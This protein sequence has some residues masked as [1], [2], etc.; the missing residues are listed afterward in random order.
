MAYLVLHIFSIFFF[1]LLSNSPGVEE[2][3]HEPPEADQ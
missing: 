1:L 3:V 2:P